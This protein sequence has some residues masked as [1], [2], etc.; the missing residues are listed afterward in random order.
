MTETWRSTL[1]DREFQARVA[2]SL[3]ISLTEA[4]ELAK[5]LLACSSLQA[6]ELVALTS[7]DP[8]AVALL[9]E[10]LLER[11]PS[12]V[13]LEATFQRIF[14]YPVPLGRVAQLK[15]SLGRLRTSVF[16][17]LP[18][19]YYESAPRGWRLP[20][21]KEPVHTLYHVL[22]QLASAPLQLDDG[23]RLHPLIRFVDLLVDYAADAGTGAT[24]RTWVDDTARQLGLPGIRRGSAGLTV[25]DAESLYLLIELRPSVG[26]TDMY[27]IGAWLFRGDMVENLTDAGE[28]PRRLSELADVIEGLLEQIGWQVATITDHLT[29]AFALPANLLNMPVDQLLV[30]VDQ[31]I[32]ASLGSLFPVVIRLLERGYTRPLRATW[33][34]FSQRFRLLVQPAQETVLT[35]A[36]PSPARSSV[37][38][39]DSLYWVTNPED[40]EWDSLAIK[41]LEDQIL[42]LVLAKPFGKLSDE[43]RKNVV[44][45]LLEAGTPI[46]LWV[47][48]NDDGE[49]LRSVLDS[50]LTQGGLPQLPAAVLHLRQRAAIEPRA[51]HPGHHLTLLWDD[52]NRIP[53]QVLLESPLRC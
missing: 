38:L 26:R 8:T 35:L 41:L 16:E 49:Q 22:I 47:R 40:Y 27:R 48:S 53:P 29:I 5:E 3:Q 39:S 34:R 50:L 36:T 33:Q 24:L 4:A 10:A 18:W 14:L 43:A 51:S 17:H 32:P 25:P 52:P 2:R 13:T 12:L 20:Q 7:G 42:G 30:T 21:E 9:I 15:A 31:R 44:D 11:E 19:I 45:A 1:S 46:A 6:D 28:P 37:S 23:T